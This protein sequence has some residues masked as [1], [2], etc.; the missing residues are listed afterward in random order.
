M[1]FRFAAAAAI[2]AIVALPGAFEDRFRQR[3]HVD[4]RFGEHDV[5]IGPVASIGQRAALDSGGQL[6]HLLISLAQRVVAPHDGGRLGHH[7]AEL[8]ARGFHLSSIS[9]DGD[10]LSGAADLQDNSHNIHVANADDDLFGD[11]F[12]ETPR[13]HCDGVGADGDLRDF[14]I[15]ILVRRR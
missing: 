10:G 1:S 7:G 9:F 3:E 6:T 13:F 4:Q 2:A 5:L 12:L 15:P 11:V 14:E 8:G